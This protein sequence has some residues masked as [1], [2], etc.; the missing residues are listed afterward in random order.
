MSNGLAENR[1]VLG[2]RPRTL[3]AAVAPVLVG[4]AVGV[5]TTPGGVD[6]FGFG[7]VRFVCALVVA[8]AVQVATNYANDYSDGKRGV[9]DPGKRVGPPRL[10]GDGL[11]TPGEV[12]RA[13]L[14]AFGVTLAAGA[15]LVIVVDWRLALVGVASVAAGWFYT[16]G[17][18]PYGYAGLGELFVFVFFGLVATVF[19][20][21]VQ[22]EQITLLA[23]LSGAAMGLLATALLVVNNLRDIPGDTESGKHTLAVRLG[24]ERTRLLY[25]GCLV[26]PFVLLPFI[27]GAS[28]R[29]VGSVA[30]AA[31][32][33]ANVAI[34]RVYR[35]AEGQALIPILARTAR[36]QL[37]FGLLLAI[38]LAVG[39]V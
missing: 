37:M 5:W 24:A 10:V 7:V 30:F 15:P 25:A 23:V 32:P 3:P 34:M 35:G 2:A 19:S 29:L 17:P 28:G 18:N 36:V 6:T 21:Y 38:G 22:S 14:V 1:W 20:A 13:M 9:D 4:T 8:L 27:A 11:A 33:L 39:P 31:L 26:G 12:K 16:G